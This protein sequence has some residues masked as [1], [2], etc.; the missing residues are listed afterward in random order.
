MAKKENEPIGTIILD[1]KY[2]IAVLPIDYS[3]ARRRKGKDGEDKFESFAWFGNISQC[4]KEYVHQTVHDDLRAKRGISL[5]EAADTA[6][7]ALERCL[8]AIQE[9]FPTYEVVK[10]EDDIVIYPSRERF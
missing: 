5:P 9:C 3:L 6:Q 4:L 1:D 8:Q 10:K 7:R 2:C